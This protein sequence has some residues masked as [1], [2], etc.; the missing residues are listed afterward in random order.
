VSCRGFERPVQAYV[1]GELAAPERARVEAHLEACEACDSRARELSRLRQVL[2]RV[3]ERR[4][5]EGFEASLAA[6]VRER[7]ATSPVLAWWDRLRL[8]LEWRYRLPALATAGSLAAALLVGVCTQGVSSYV[9]GQERSR[10]ISAAVERH[11]E[12]PAVN[13]DAVDAS[14][15]LSTGDLVTE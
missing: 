5:S 2:R 10:Y 13:W 12:L 11:E 8:R 4:V 1:D 15:E 6:A 14:I 7:E 3:P 9:A